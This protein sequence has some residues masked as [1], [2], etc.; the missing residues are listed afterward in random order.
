MTLIIAVAGLVKVLSDK[1]FCTERDE[2]FGYGSYRKK[3]LR[4]EGILKSFVK[5]LLFYIAQ[6]DKNQLI[7]WV[8]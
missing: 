6:Q 4:P 2:R 7:I 5:D 3:D 1:D 8:K